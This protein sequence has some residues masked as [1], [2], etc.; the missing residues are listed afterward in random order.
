MKQM[1]HMM[2]CVDVSMGSAQAT[3]CDGD[4]L[5]FRDVLT[6]TGLRCPQALCRAPL[7]VS[8]E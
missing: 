4:A 5:T 2:H 3:S 6:S 1:F 8:L 7:S